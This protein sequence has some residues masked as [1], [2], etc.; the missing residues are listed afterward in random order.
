MMKLRNILVIAIMA[1]TATSLVAA[2][3]IKW[4][5]KTHD[6]GAFK[7]EIGEVSC[8]MQFVNVGDEPVVITQARVTC[9]C[10]T[11]QYPKS[12]IAPGDTA[13]VTVTYSALGRPGRFNKKVYLYSNTDERST[14]TISGVVVGAEN[15]IKSRFP[16]DAGKLKLRNSTVAFGEMNRGNIKTAFLDAYNQTTDTLYPEWKNVPKYLSVI[17]APKAVAPGEQTTF[18]FYLNTTECPEW[19]IN[20]IDINLIPT[21]GEKE[22]PVS[23]VV[24]VK[25]DFTKLTPGQRA[26]APKIEI[27]P[28]PVDFGVVTFNNGIISKSFDIKNIGK[29]TLEIRRIYT[30]DAGVSLD[31]NIDKIKKDKSKSVTVNVDTSKI[32]PELLN[33]RIIVIT[34]DPDNPQ[35][36][37]RIVGEVK[38]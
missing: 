32:S 31:F 26:K 30:T 5:K 29:S 38:H 23:V 25:E 21:K 1:L 16:V 8:E 35:K 7:E 12:G 17:S 37:V 11:P 13:T 27:S 33:A 4:I 14:L 2:P 24:I 20:N 28:E 19:G 9:G 6:F 15:T 3:K 22:I 34:N 18:S 36:I 10:T